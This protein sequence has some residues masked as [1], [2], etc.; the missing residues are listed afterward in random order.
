MR[1]LTMA[2]VLAVATYVLR[3]DSTTVAA[4]T[5]LAALE[6]AVGEQTGAGDTATAAAGLLRGLVR[7][8]PFGGPNRTIA[9]ASVIQLLALNG[10]DIELEPA[11]ELDTLLDK[12]A[13]DALDLT[14]LADQ[15]SLRMVPLSQRKHDKHQKG[16]AMF[17]RFSN[18]GR[19]VVVLAQEEA[20][21]LDH[22][23]IGTEHVLLALLRVEDSVAAT[24]LAQLG[25]TLDDAHAEIEA[26]V[27]RGT[28]APDGHIP[29][30]ARA[31]KVL[32]LSLRESLTFGAAEVDTEHILLG[33]LR[34][35]KGAGGQVLIKRGLS[36]AAVR[37]AIT[38]R[39][40]R[41]PAGSHQQLLRDLTAVFEE[42]ARLRGEVSRL[43]GLLRDHG[44]DPAA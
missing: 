38:A 8:R 12:V 24:V 20:R 36:L 44:V 3:R 7:R 34:E 39:P 18:R 37:D 5:D 17:E 40:F 6:L 21:D 16:E 14:A 33:L 30:T 41:M 27:G 13:A 43:Q 23:Y 4:R 31:K 42:N 1:L 9:V 15:L 35:G 2:E 32:E 29:F 26:S 25:V 11:D 19:Q 10:C 22:N 28:R